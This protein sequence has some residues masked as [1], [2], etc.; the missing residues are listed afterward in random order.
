TGNYYEIN[1]S[2]DIAPGPKYS[3]DL[4]AVDT[5]GNTMLYRWLKI[6]ADTTAV[7]DRRYVQFGGTPTNISYT[8][9]Y[10]YPA[11]YK[12]YTGY[13]PGHNMTN[14]DI[15]HHDQGPDGTLTDSG[16]L[17]GSLPTSVIQE[18]HCQ[19]YVGYWYDET[20]TALPG[21]IKNIYHHFW[22]RTDN[23]DLF[24]AYGK[25]DAG[26]YRTDNWTQSYLTNTGNAHSSL[27][28][29][30]LT[31]YLESNIMNITTPQSFTDN[32]IYEHFV[33]YYTST[34]TNP[35][36]I[37]NRSILSF[38]IF[39]VPDKTVL[40]GMDTDADGLTD[41]Q[42]LY[43]VFTNPFLQDTDNDGFSD[44]IE[45]NTGSDPN[46]YLSKSTLNPIL[47]AETPQNHSTIQPLNQPL[48]ITVFQAQNHVMN[49]TF[50]TNATGS[51]QTIGTNLSISNG[52][53]TQ[54]PTTMN[55][56]DTTYY[57]SINCSD[58]YTWTNETY[59]FTTQEEPRGWIYYKK[60]TVNHLLVNQSLKNFPI[61]I[62]ITDTDLANHAQP[63]AHD[64]QFWDVTNTT[65][66]HH[67]IEKYNATTGE[68]IAWVNIT[69]LSATQD[70]IIWMR[71]GNNTCGSQE[72]VAGTWDSN[73]IMVQHLNKTGGT[74]YDSTI[75]NNDGLSTGTDYTSAGQID[76]ARQ[77]NDSDKIVVNSF[78]HSPTALT[79]EAWVYR[80][81][82]AFQYIYCKGT[83]STSSDWIFY[84][85]NN[86]PAGQGIDFG[87]NNHGKS[88][89]TGDTPVN[90]WFYLTATYSSGSA[91]LYFNGTKIGSGTGW[92]SITNAYPH[93][94]MGND[95]MGNN[96]GTYPMTQVKLDEL[97]VSKIA[98]NSSWIITSYK[99]ISNPTTF[100]NIGSEEQTNYNPVISEELPL[101]QSIAQPLNP[102]LSVTIYQAQNLPM[103]VTF[104]TNAS[105]SWQTIGTNLSVPNGK[106]TQA[107]TTMNNYDTTYYW[108]VNCSAGTLWTN[109]TY[110]FTTKTAPINNPPLITNPGPVNE[111]TGIPI[112]MTSLNITIEDPEG[113]SFN[114][115]I[116]TSPNIG[117]NSSHGAINGTKRCTMPGLAY[118]T[119]Y[120]WTVTATDGHKWTNRTYHFTTWIGPRGW[121][122]YKKIT[123]KHSLVNQSLT[124]FPI[125]IK[126]T[127]VDLVNHAQP[128]ARDV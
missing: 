110:R 47:S 37:N 118:N 100:I 49:I 65:R 87:I 24:V 45:Y 39:N 19:M 21:T 91:A 128:D 23:H 93:L 53:Y 123:V 126:T 38:V 114:W 22:W 117:S 3:F 84:L 120:H 68:F 66:Y 99:T 55:N 74:V 95:Y 67:E 109:E 59:S 73:Y 75:Y 51:W 116:T 104:K 70:T 43:L 76:G 27:T 119:T 82:T 26:F 79:T 5:S 113:E 40:Q 18:R 4:L 41:Y 31:Y 78:T 48:S 7:D 81:S 8:P 33:E 98:R 15:L 13:G 52:R 92:P 57:W 125:L 17:L 111:S 12:Y 77:Y 107:P 58:G 16:Y 85:R 36:I 46:N 83:S 97:R 6:G 56:Y 122:Y 112:T 64:I 62:S 90:S 108:A 30:S 29:N 14:D 105:G 102:P 101:N 72:N 35:S 44:Y 89:R 71:Y 61:L 34:T 10:F 28:Y 124:N 11:Q 1:M 121:I 42:E 69:Y 9:Y 88:I 115:T 50:L 96:G 54:T 103:N 25:T 94:G 20:L 60:I 127:D 86:L 2:T 106:Y 63:T 32:D 80:D